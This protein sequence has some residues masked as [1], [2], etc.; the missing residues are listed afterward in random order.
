MGDEAEK[1]KK[2]KFKEWIKGRNRR[3]FLENFS[4]IVIV[5]SAV[6]VCIGISLGSF[7]KGTVLIGSFGSFT[8]MVGIVI[9]IVSQFIGEEHGKDALKEEG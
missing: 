2:I 1:V 4:F 6:L 8:V 3:E 5:I 9:Y 7:V